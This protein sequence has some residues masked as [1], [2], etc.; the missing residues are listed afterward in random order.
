[1]GKLKYPAIAACLAAFCLF[2][3]TAQRREL[4][5]HLFFEPYFS[6]VYGQIDEYVYQKYNG[7]WEQLSRL[8]WEEKPRWE[9]GIR[10]GG[11]YKK[12]NVDLHLA[13]SFAAKSGEMRDSD[14]QNTADWGMKTNYSVSDNKVSSYLDFGGGIG[15]TFTPME[16][17]SITP[18]LEAGYT[19]ILFKAFDGEA[20]YGTS[21][22]P[23][24]SW[25][26]PAAEHFTFDGNIIDYDRWSIYTYLGLAFSFT[27]IERLSFDL[28]LAA[29]PYTYT[30]STDTHHLRSLKFKD[31]TSSVFKHFK[32]SAAVR[33][34]FNDTFSLGLSADGFLGLENKGDSY[35]TSK[36]SDSYTKFAD[37]QGGHATKE[38]AVS[39]FL[40]IY[41]F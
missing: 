23:Y 19:N 5:F 41:V 40:T 22:T 2:P 27:P 12:L 39:L 29:S 10:V 8:E 37:E 13:S 33:Y 14:W 34:S 36:K 1:M 16:K 30:E 25:D 17:F 32:G 18:R 15:F 3:C 38:F 6:C 9:Y 26:D 24:T 4:D 28:S 35:Y 21:V 20:W 31:V 7:S 11:A